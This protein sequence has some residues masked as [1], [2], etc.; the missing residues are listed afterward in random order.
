M[1]KNGG[2]LWNE[3]GFSSEKIVFIIFVVILLLKT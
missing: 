2:E 1:K 3:L